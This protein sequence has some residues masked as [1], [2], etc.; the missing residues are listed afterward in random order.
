[1]KPRRVDLQ[2]AQTPGDVMA[3]VIATRFA[4]ADALAS[5]L[6]R[7]EPHGLHALRIA[8]KRLRYALER[9]ADRDER[10][11]QIAVEFSKLQD[12]LGETHDRDVLLTILPP[13]LRETE[14]RLRADRAAHAAAARELWP[15]L[16]DMLEGLGGEG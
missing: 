13:T 10:L 9:F 11:G 7:A 1:M 8:C 2:G 3:R 6:E 12:A 5:E 15:R 4:E 14:R 16:R